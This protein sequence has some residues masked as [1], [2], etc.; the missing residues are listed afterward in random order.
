MKVRSWYG[1][2]GE[3]EVENE[4]WHLV[5]IGDI[6]LHHPPLVNLALRRGLPQNDRLRLSYLHE[7]GHFQTLP[8]ALAHIL[9]VAWSS[10]T[11]RHSFRGWLVWLV[12]LTVAH[13]A[14]WEI[15]SV[16]YVVLEDLATYRKVYHQVPNHL[17]PLFWFGLSGLGTGLSL[18]L[19]RKRI[20]PKG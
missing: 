19:I 4:L 3:I 8:L 18:L 11:Q 7:F 13:E 14:V 16:T 5:K 10:R 9:F 6:A 17:L 20:S 1:L 2:T 12:D 15:L